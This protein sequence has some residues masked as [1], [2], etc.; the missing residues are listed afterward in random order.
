MTAALKRRRLEAGAR[1][2]IDGEACAVAS[3][4]A[5]GRR[6]DSDRWTDGF[7]VRAAEGCQAWRDA[8]GRW[9]DET[10]ERMRAYDEAREVAKEAV[11][12]EAA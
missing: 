7:Y 10:P 11:D 8:G 1:W 4:D 12:D 9:P 5:S 3:N 2:T 6:V